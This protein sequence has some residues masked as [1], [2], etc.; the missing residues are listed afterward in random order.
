VGK[1]VTISKE[2]LIGAFEEVKALTDPNAAN[3]KRIVKLIE[4]YDLPREAL[5]TEVLN[6]VKVWDALLRKMPMT[7]MIRNLGKMSSIGLLKTNLSDEVKHVVA[8]LTNPNA[9]KKARVHPI[10]LL[11]A[12][13]TYEKGHGDKG[14][15][16]WKPVSHIVD[17]LNDAFYMAFDHVEPTGQNWMLALD[18]SG[19]MASAVAGKTSLT[20]A[21]AVAAMAMVTARVEP[22]YEIVGFAQTIKDL[23]ISRQDRLDAV[24]RKTSHQNFGSTDCAAAV[25]HALNNDIRVD[26]FVIY[27]DNET[28]AGRDGHPV[29]V[30]RRYRKETGIAAKM[31]V[32]ATTATEV[33]IADPSDAGMLDVAGFDPTVPQVMAEFSKGTM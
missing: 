14:S 29:Q 4:E 3:I 10:S 26:T 31:I 2:S 22:N 15:L 30:L 23:K 27:T 7:A 16:A 12:L 5:P 25:L 11:V 17:A 1:E 19:S 6:D 21:E 32:V 24:L 33:S 9:L 18:V 8:N 20:A 13:K 28:W